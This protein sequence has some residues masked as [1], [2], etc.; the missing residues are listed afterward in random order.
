MA[1]QWLVAPVI[2]TAHWFD[3]IGATCATLLPWVEHVLL[4]T[5]FDATRESHF[6]SELPRRRPKVLLI[7]TE[8]HVCVLQTGLGLARLGLEPILV[9]VCVGSRRPAALVAAQH[10]WNHHGLEQISDRQSTLLNSS[11]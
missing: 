2:A 8:A 3:K 9:A 11:H 6:Q 10:R 5:H 7:G 1:A 4:K